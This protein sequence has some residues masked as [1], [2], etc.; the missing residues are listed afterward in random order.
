MS[1]DLNHYRV[2]VFRQDR[3]HG[4][5]ARWTAYTMWAH[6]SW[7]GCIVVDVQA[8]SGAQAKREAIKVAKA[9]HALARP[10]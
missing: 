4:R 7:D 8:A 6:P 10:P 2:Y 3:G 1:L 5:A 9:K